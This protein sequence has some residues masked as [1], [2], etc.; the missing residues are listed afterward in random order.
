MHLKEHIGLFNQNKKVVLY[1]EH[2]NQST[3][4]MKHRM[5]IQYRVVRNLKHTYMRNRH[6]ALVYLTRDF[7]FTKDI[8]VCVVMI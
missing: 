4:L 2:Y 6:P 3:D 1:I 7:V 8:F 5:L